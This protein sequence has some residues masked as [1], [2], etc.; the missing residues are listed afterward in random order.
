MRADD[1]VRWVVAED[2]AGRPRL[3]ASCKQ[4]LPGIHCRNA[5][6]YVCD[7]CNKPIC[8]SHR[9]D[10]NMPRLVDRDRDAAIRAGLLHQWPKGADG[11]PVAPAV[12]FRDA[13]TPDLCTTCRF[14]ERSFERAI[15]EISQ[16]DR[17]RFLFSEEAVGYLGEHE[18][19]DY[20]GLRDHHGRI[21][22]KEHKR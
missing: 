6:D 12:R 13:D 17:R 21:H 15:E 14:L 3:R 1:P 8:V 7:S 5:V 11:E 2:L 19:S 20:E 4:K 10:A 9:H 16:D 18:Y 22:G